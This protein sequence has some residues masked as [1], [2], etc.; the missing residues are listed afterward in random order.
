MLRFGFRSFSSFW[1]LISTA[2]ATADI[3]VF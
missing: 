1:P 2:I 3:K